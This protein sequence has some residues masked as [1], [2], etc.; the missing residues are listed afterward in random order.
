M[1]LV[2]LALLP[3]M[4]RM[5]EEGRLARMLGAPLYWI[6]RRFR[7]KM[8]ALEQ[9]QTEAENHG[10][11][12]SGGRT[13][14]GAAGVYIARRTACPELAAEAASRNFWTSTCCGNF[15]FYFADAAG[16]LPAAV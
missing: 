15:F 5:H 10:A 2:G 1:G 3:G 14:N 7:W 6:R 11:C 13:G 12:W 9:P 16:G 8:P 4:E